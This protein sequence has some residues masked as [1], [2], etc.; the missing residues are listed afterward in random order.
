MGLQSQKVNKFQEYVIVSIDKDM[1]S[2][3]C[4]L[5]SNGKD[6]QKISKEQA[7]Y[8]F[9]F[10][11]LVGDST[12]NFL[13]CPSVGPKKATLILDNANNSYWEAIVKAFDKV[14][15]TENDAIIQAQMAYILREKEDYNFETKEV[16]VWQPKK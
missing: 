16:N 15:L 1:K 2:I 11:T 8:N 7:D 9:A 12:D 4:L 13:G 3:P 6:I 14:G 5:S 10:Q